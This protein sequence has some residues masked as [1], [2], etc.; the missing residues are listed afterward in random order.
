M[1]DTPDTKLDQPGMKISNLYSEAKAEKREQSPKA[2]C[3][4]QEALGKSKQRIVKKRSWLLLL[5]VTLALV[6]AGGFYIA[7]QRPDPSASLAKQTVAVREQNQTIRI[8]ASGTVVPIATVNISPK[9]AGRLAALYVDQ[10]TRVKAGQLIARMDD[11]YL[12]AELA[13]A[14]AELAQAVA[15][16]TKTRVGN[17]REAIARARAQVVSAQAKAD[18]TQ[19]RV[20]RYRNLANQGAVTQ[21]DLDSKISDDRSAQASLQEAQQQLQEQ[22][23]GSRIED[24]NASAQ[25]VEAAR[26]KVAQAQTNLNEIMIRAPFSGIVTQKYATVGAIVT[27]TTSASSTASAT[28]TSIVALASKLE[29]KINVPETD[30]AQVRDGQRVEIV[31]DSYPERTFE[32]RVRLIAPETVVENNV[33]SFQVRV[34]LVSGLSA[35]RSGMNVN[36]AFIGKSIPHALTVPTVAIVTQQGKTGVLLP[37]THG[38]GQF[39]PVTVGTTQG[40]QTQILKGV[41][42]GERVFIDFPEGKTPQSNPIP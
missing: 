25:K 12:Q 31:A 42:A 7:S 38:K 33:T 16:Y 29:L 9:N 27:P 26:A 20:K 23:T 18:L 30:I 37:D 35:L 34:K 22:A 2:S 6:G 39:H 8:E 14:K 19:E 13:Q 21:D 1:N 32:G 5:V 17:R 41:K 11:A 10:G 4:G 3:A 24:I 36:V 28:S 40:D 15:D